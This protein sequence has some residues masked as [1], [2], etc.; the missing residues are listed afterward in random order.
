MSPREHGEKYAVIKVEDFDRILRQFAAGKGE[1]ALLGEVLVRDAVVIRRQDVF[2]APA[3]H[4]Y[5][6]AMAVAITLMPEGPDR[7]RLIEVADYF[8]HEATL[9]EQADFRKL[10]D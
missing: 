1:L 10:P 9:A 5:A 8:H 4:A 7:R 3:L 6:S 2:A